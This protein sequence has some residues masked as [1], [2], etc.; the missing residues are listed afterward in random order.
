MLAYSRTPLRASGIQWELTFVGKSRI[1]LNF[2]W[3]KLLVIYI[4]LVLVSFVLHNF[5]WRWCDGIWLMLWSNLSGLD[6]ALPL[7]TDKI[8][9]K[10]K[11][12]EM[13][14]V[15]QTNAGHYGDI[16]SIGDVNICANNGNTQ[17]FCQDSAGNLNIDL[18]L[19]RNRLTN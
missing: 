15:I 10:R 12:A 9:L 13:V 5:V 18:S 1:P 8:R 14:H 6:P 3:K 16:G 19:R 17:P 4:E 7:I 11:A 2:Q